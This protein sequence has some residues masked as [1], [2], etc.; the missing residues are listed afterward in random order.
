MA[1][2]AQTFRKRELRDPGIVRAIF[3]NTWLSPIWLFLRLYLGY[4]W[5]MAG[6]H[7]VWGGG[8]WIAVP[9][10]D[11][12]ALK[13]YW[14]RVTA[15]PAQGNPPIAFGWYRHFLTF[16]LNHGWY[17]WFSWV[18]SLGE[19]AVGIAL[20]VG[21]FVGVAAFFGA[22]M[23]FNYLMA[24]SASINP[25]MFFVAILVI[26]G[27]KTAGWIGLDR[28]LL[29]ALGTP[30]QPG[31]VVKELVEQRGREPSEE[32]VRGTGRRRGPHPSPTG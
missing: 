25:V 21:A 1:L 11:G 14:Q 23:N 29:P 32:A 3:A 9:G 30:W 5:L 27:W 31:T 20:I 22:L 2:L 13:G 10:P 17:H 24:G 15:I 12:L 4:Q 7:K 8:R 19:V 6:A 28:W 18:V 26:V 16:M